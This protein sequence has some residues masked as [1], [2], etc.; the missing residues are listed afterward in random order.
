MLVNHRSVKH[1]FFSPYFLT[2]LSETTIVFVMFCK[3]VRETILVLVLSM[4]VCFSPYFLTLESETMFFLPTFWHLSQ[5]PCFILPTFSHLSQKPCF[6]SRLFDTWVNNHVFFCLLFGTTVGNH[7]R[8]CNVLFC[9]SVKTILVLSMRLFLSL[10]VGNSVR[11]HV[12]L[13]KLLLS[14][15]FYPIFYLPSFCLRGSFNFIFPK[16][17]QS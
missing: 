3:S 7:F 9:K 5:K 15:F 2:L 8:V 11:N 14:L 10:C 17:P 6:F 12:M 1:V 13:Q 4:F 16:F